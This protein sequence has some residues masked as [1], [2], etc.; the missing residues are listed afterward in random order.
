MVTSLYLFNVFTLI[1]VLL[2]SNAQEA[3]A[4][5]INKEQD[6]VVSIQKLFVKNNDTITIN[7][8]SIGRAILKN[9]KINEFKI[10]QMHFNIL[11]HFPN[12]FSD[13]GIS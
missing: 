11:E 2:D 8:S 9:I 3:C 13:F 5:F 4:Y 6:K 12:V 1:I 7:D 10:D